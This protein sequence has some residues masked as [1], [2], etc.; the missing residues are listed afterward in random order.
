MQY[1]KHFLFSA[2]YKKA[3]VKSQPACS[4]VPCGYQNK[5]LHLTYKKISHVLSYKKLQEINSIDHVENPRKRAAWRI[6]ITGWIR[7][8]PFPPKRTVASTFPSSAGTCA[9]P[10]RISLPTSTLTR[11]RRTPPCSLPPC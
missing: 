3:T 2:T 5:T 7:F 10:C 8:F 6:Q 11:D 4:T 9:C 1:F